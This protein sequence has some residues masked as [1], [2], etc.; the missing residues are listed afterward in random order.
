MDKKKVCGERCGLGGE[1]WLGGR[2]RLG[3][4]GPVSH[5]KDVYFT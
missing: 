4:G 1:M 3:C 5:D 2:E